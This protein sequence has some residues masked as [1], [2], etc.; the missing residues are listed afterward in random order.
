MFA[1][2]AAEVE[3]AAMWLFGAWFCARARMPVEIKTIKYVP[4][5]C[6][7]G[8][9]TDIPTKHLETVEVNDTVSTHISGGK[10]YYTA[11]WEILEFKYL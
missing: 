4:S 1:E 10:C 2:E 8:V 3:P 11:K 9:F 7:M 5:Y 6:F